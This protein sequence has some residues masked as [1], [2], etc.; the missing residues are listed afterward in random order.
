M[1]KK[2]LFFVVLCYVL[3]GTLPLYWHLLSGVGAVLVLCCR[4]I[5]AAIFSVLVLLCMK[6]GKEIIAMLK[7]RA[8]MKYLLIAAPVIC[9]NWGVYIWA[10]SVGRTLDASLGYYMNP[11]V[12]FLFSTLLFKEKCGRLQL[13]AII[14]AAV[15]VAISVLLYGKFPYVAL[16][17]ALCF[18]LYGVLKKK[19]HTDPIVSMAVETLVMTPF[20]LIF[21]LLFQREAVA[22]LQSYEAVLLMLGGALTA[23]P[24]MLYASAVNHLPFIT[25]GFTQYIN[26]TLMCISGLILGETLTTDKILSLGFILV[27]LVIY[28][29]GMVRD[30]KKAKAEE[31]A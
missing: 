22:A 29:V 15:G 30:D 19:A 7:D 1:D 3:W 26:P 8:V 10:V 28:S 13:V 20:F 24:L 27:A 12:V 23:I 11:L 21:A 6:R 4:L 18:A 16:I 17:L 31:A 5:F 9:I 25:V 14:V 2:N